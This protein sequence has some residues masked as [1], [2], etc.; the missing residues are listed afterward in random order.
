MLR[1]IVLLIF[2]VLLCSAT[3]KGDKKGYVRH[4]QKI[5]KMSFK[6][7]QNG[8][9]PMDAFIIDKHGLIRPIKDLQSV[10]KALMRREYGKGT[11]AAVRQVRRVRKGIDAEIVYEI[12]VK[13]A[14]VGDS[15]KVFFSDTSA[16]HISCMTEGHLGVSVYLTSFGKA[17]YQ[18]NV[19]TNKEIVSGIP[20]FNL[21]ELIG[22]VE[23]FVNDQ[24]S[25][26]FYP[27]SAA[28]VRYPSERVR[29]KVVRK[30]SIKIM[31]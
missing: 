26:A 25:F 23:P 21:K 30:E 5:G 8:T 17:A 27:D 13:N 18:C 28:N 22:T 16:V 6:R 24:I 11:R 7:F 4:Q 31:G 20:E 3:G 10:S 2:V 19:R 9:Y 14:R 29:M 1:P 15:F 12:E